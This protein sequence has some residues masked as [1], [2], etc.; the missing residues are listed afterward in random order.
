MHNRIVILG[1][2]FKFDGIPIPISL[3]KFFGIFFFSPEKY[4]TSSL[5]MSVRPSVVPSVRL[6]FEEK[7]ID[8][9]SEH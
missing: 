5:A 7:T 2:V 4:I 9:S 1:K 6:S 3:W 8:N